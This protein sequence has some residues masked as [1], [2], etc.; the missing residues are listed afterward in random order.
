VDGENVMLTQG[1]WVRFNEDYIDQL[2]TYVDGIAMEETE[3]QFQQLS[4][5]EDVFNKSNEIGARGYEDA[6]KDF[7]K[8]KTS[9]STL[10]EAWDLHK[11]GT[12]YAVKFGTAQKVGY[13]CDQA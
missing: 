3:S 6:D 2:N 12:V 5:A 10:V 9:A 1:R 4:G 11:G 8:I 7:S 13:V